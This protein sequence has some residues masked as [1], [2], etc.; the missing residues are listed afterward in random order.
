MTDTGLCHL[1]VQGPWRLHRQRF[2]VLGKEPFLEQAVQE[3]RRSPRVRGQPWSCSGG[4]MEPACVVPALEGPG[5]WD[6]CP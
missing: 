4:E 2:K 6:T 5:L 1:N 3:G